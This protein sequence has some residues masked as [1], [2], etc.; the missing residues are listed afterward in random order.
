M[1]T[2]PAIPRGWR[3]LRVGTIVRLGDKFWSY[4]QYWRLVDR[5]HSQLPKVMRCETVIRRVAKK[6]KRK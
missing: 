1:T 2:H 6:G 5:E 3:R 4:F